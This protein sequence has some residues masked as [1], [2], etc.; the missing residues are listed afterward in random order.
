MLRKI[1]TAATFL[2]G[3]TGLSAQDSTTE[4]KSSKPIIS[5]YADVYY[6][7]DFQKQPANNKTS[8]TNSHNSFELNMASIKLEHSIGKVGMVA[9]IGFGKR[10][11]EFSYNDENTRFAIKQLFIT[12]APGEHVKLTAGSWATHVGYELV[13]PTGNRN[14]SMSYMFSYG[15]F[16]HTGVKTDLTFGKHNFMVGIANPHDLKTTTSSKK[17]LVAQYSTGTESGK[18][19]GYLNYQGGSSSDSTKVNQVDAVITATVSDKFTLGYN[20][21]VAMFEMNPI[22]KKSISS[23][24]WGSAVYANYDPINWFGLTLR[25]E[26]FSDDDMATSVFASATKGGNIFANTLSANLKVKNLTL[27]PEL[28]FEKASQNIFLK[29]TGQGSENAASFLMAAVYRF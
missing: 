5:G 16:F 18:L 10:A 6:R 29:S 4:E 28:R 7:Y 19:K 26:Y 25:S 2:A 1:L 20:G 22:G 21:T 24:W 9:D 3:S 14:Y 8:F 17:F 23:K 13:D 15:P 27:I 12:Y 11:E